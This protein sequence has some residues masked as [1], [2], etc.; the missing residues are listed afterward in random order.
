MLAYNIP[1]FQDGDVDTF[2]L[3]LARA[4][5]RIRKVRFRFDLERMLA[6]L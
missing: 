4:N 3:S 6:H 2:L 5:G 1:Y